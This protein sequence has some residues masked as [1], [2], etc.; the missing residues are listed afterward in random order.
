[1]HYLVESYVAPAGVLIEEIDGRARSATDDL[2]REGATIRFVRSI[3]VPEDEMCVLQYDASSRELALEAARRAGLTSDRVVEMLEG[4]PEDAMS[5]G[6]WH[7][8]HR[9][10]R[11]RRHHHIG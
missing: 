3:L 1:V 4:P 11:Y 5:S 7:G 10:E 2:A 8:L 6:P 9:H